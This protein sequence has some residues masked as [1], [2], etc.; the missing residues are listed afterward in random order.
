MAVPPNPHLV[1]RMQGHRLSIFGEMSALAVETGAINLGQG[2]PDTDGPAEVTTAAIQ[3]I[4]D[5]FNQ[6]PPDRGI[7]ELRQAVADHQARFYDQHVDPDNVVVATGA[8]EALGATVMALVE[9]G[10][11]VIV[12]EPYFD[13]YAAVI[14]LAGG[15]RRAVTLRTPDYSFDPAELEAAIKPSTRMIMVNTPHNPTGKVFSQAELGEIARLAIAHDLVVVTD[16]VYEHMTYDGARHIPLATLPGMAERT[17]TISSGGKSFGLTGWKVG[18]VHAPT[19]LVGAVHTVKQ[20]L[21][22]TSGA[23]FQRAMVTALNLGDDYFTGLADDLRVRRDLIVDGLAS[24]GLTVYPAMG[25]YYVTVD[26]GPL[27]YD[28]GMDFCHDLPGRCGVVAGP[29]R[30]FY[31]EQEAGRSIVRFAYCKRLEVLHEAIERLSRLAG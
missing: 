8:S 13:L 28:D 5:G 15:V 17:V 7:P 6:Y 30:V 1:A 22:F 24:V 2:F 18:W 11:E 9:P 4:R 29:T 27:G 31:D 26:V 10:Q 12:F 21:S 25:T 20:H 16:E 19:E 14:E 23:P 3:A